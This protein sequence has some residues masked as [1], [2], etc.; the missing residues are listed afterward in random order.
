MTTDYKDTI[1][2]PQTDFPMRAGLPRKE[3]ELLARWAEM[4][5]YTRQR[6]ESEGRPPFILHDGPPYANGH[7]HIGHALNKILKDVISRSQQ[8]RGRDSN[9]VPGWD[10]H[11]LPI[12]WKIEEQY[13]AAGRNKDEVPIPEFRKECRE[14]AEHWV[15]VQSEEFQRLGVIGNWDDP[16]TTMAHH[17]EAQ[18]AREIAKFAMN[19]GLYRGARP[20]LWSVVEKTALADAEVEYEDHVSHSIYVRFPLLTASD[21]ALEGAAIVIWTTTPWT[22][23]GNRAIAVGPELDYVRIAVRGVAE[24]SR[25]AVGDE[26]VLAAA[27]LEA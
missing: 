15:G 17:A 16:Y 1:F 4:D 5:L 21:P 2:L 7:L 9:Y 11:G 14:F 6:A 3:P 13:R 24:N 19:G 18:I 27:L 22:I 12:E 23:P 10:C 8:M 25:V 20:V 26:L